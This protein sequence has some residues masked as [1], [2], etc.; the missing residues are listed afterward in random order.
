MLI[1]DDFYDIDT[2]LPADMLL[3]NIE[4]TGLSPRNAFI[5]MIGMGWLDNGRCHFRC[6]L[7]ESRMDERK[8]MTTFYDQIKEFNR[9]LTYGGQ[10]F[11][12]RFMENRWTNYSTT[13]ESLF[14][15]IQLK[16]IQ[17]DITP[18]KSFL[19]LPDLKKYTVEPFV[20]F[21]RRDTLSGK[22]LIAVF[23][24]WERSHD[25]QGTGLLL[26]HHREDMLSLLQ[27]RKLKSY[28]SFWKG[29]FERVLSWQLE[30]DACRFHLRLKTSVPHPLQYQTKYA[31]ITI[32][33]AKAVVMLNAYHGRLK[34]FLPGPVKDYFYLPYEDQAM[35]R[36]IAR[37]VD[38]EHRQKATAATCY[39]WREGYFLPTDDKSVQP[40]F[41]TDYQSKPYYISYEP[42]NWK[43]NPDLLKK[44]LASCII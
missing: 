21:N 29:D 23:S 13:D 38:K 40:H 7:A 36:S 31:D 8:V 15:D 39:T 33:D 35:H 11:T 10:S 25:D 41:Q 6:L 24:E 16:D 32:N 22:E 3:L 27:L 14:N 2:I 4:T 12:W 28:T 37:Y 18:Y 44:Y 43:K 1:F 19:P 5:F 30:N 9:I 26:E 42:E 20:G 34:Y 17:K